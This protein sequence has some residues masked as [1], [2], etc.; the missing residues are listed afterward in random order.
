[1][2]IFAAS[3]AR[4]EHLPQITEIFAECLYRKISTYDTAI[5]GDI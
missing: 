2:R 1:M 3:P 4:K 5:D